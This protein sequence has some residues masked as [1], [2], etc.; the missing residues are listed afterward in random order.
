MYSRVKSLWSSHFS[1]PYICYPTYLVASF[2]RTR[3]WKKLSTTRKMKYL[4]LNSFYHVPPPA[5]P[6]FK[7][8]PLQFSLYVGRWGCCISYWCNATN[9]NNTHS[10]GW[11]LYSQPLLRGFFLRVA[12]KFYAP[13]FNH[14]LGN[15]AH[16]GASEVLNFTKSHKS[17]NNSG[18]GISGDLQRCTNS[19]LANYNRKMSSAWPDDVLSV[20]C[21][22]TQLP[23]WKALYYDC[24]VKHVFIFIK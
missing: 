4:E 15:A 24:G 1:R 19:R 16:S 3:F 2:Q 20:L 13:A 12:F 14:K 6:P 17:R 8:I 5:L 23:C 10:R 18:K 21:S 7:V 9:Y 11:W 22:L